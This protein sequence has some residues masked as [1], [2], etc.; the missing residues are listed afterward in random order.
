MSSLA[1]SLSELF[2]YLLV[3]SRVMGAILMIPGLGSQYINTPV[4]ILFAMA[5]SAV[6]APLLMGSMPAAP[7][8][9]VMF[10]SYVIIESLIGIFIGTMGRMLL[11]ALELAGTII[12]FQSG[13]MNAFVL[14]PVDGHQSPLP[15]TYLSVMVLALIFVADIHHVALQAVFD[16]YRLFSPGQFASYDSITN[17]FMQSIVT[18]ISEAFILGTQ[19]A[20]PII[21]L[22]MLFFV[23]MGLLNRLM[24][25]LQVFFL[26][27][28]FQIFIGFMILSMIVSSACMSMIER[29]SYLYT[30]IW[31]VRG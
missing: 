24:P 7:H 29:L 8:D 21:I 6:M 27:Q 31:N 28:P 19:I 13:L 25:Q 4:R 9:P 26:A 5:I 30:N 2:P 1:L 15:A 10:F 22:S 23:G 16:S 3:L 14:N 18:I 11:S 20:A 12:G 17:D